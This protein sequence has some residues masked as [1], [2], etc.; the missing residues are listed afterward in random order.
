[1]TVKEGGY[2][3]IH[4]PDANG[5]L[6]CAV[7]RSQTH[8]ANLPNHRRAEVEHRETLKQPKLLKERT[9]LMGPVAQPGFAETERAT[10][11]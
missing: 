9:E 11:S 10:G 1:M 8:S 3:R 5:P 6:Q 7:K 4:Q 2:L